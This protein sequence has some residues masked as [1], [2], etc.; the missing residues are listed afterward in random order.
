MTPLE[1]IRLTPLMERAS[2]R[3]DVTIGFIDGPVAVHP[4]LAS[5]H[6]R[7]IP[8]KGSGTCGKANS[9]ACLHGTFVAGILSASGDRL[10]PQ[11]VPTPAYWC[12]P[13]LPK[14]KP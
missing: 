1:L 6:I 12:D 8:G 11:F 9:A 14:Q 4:E 13:S 2:G 5:Q 10:P 3:P 7:E